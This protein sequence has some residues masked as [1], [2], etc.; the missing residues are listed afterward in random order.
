MDT[1]TV[2]FK[3]HSDSD[4]NFKHDVFYKWRHYLRNKNTLNLTNYNEDSIL[5]SKNANVHS[6]F[7]NH[8][9]LVFIYI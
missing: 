3:V 7:Q 1:T 8:D 2:D 5:F 4:I 6:N 9:Y